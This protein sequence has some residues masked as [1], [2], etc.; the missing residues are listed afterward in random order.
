MKSLHKRGCYEPL[1][2]FLGRP[3]YPRNFLL[4]RLRNARGRPDEDIRNVN[5]KMFII[6]S[7]LS[8]IRPDTPCSLRRNYFALEEQN[9]NAMHNH[10]GGKNTG[11]P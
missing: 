2:V 5:A 10:N 6:Q 9:V 3:I 1:V 7:L 8:L 11:K 4:G